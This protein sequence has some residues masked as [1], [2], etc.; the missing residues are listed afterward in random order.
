MAN[1]TVRH[2]WRKYVSHVGSLKLG[3]VLISDEGELE[4]G[5]GDFN[6][7]CRFKDTYQSLLMRREEK[8]EKI[9]R[10]AEQLSSQKGNGPERIYSG[11]G[12]EKKL[13]LSQLE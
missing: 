6:H 3:C 13:T 8:K 4:G 2:G 10:A 5:R 11:G 9:P 7:S 12:E 1:C